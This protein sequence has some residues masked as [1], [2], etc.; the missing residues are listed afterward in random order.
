MSSFQGAILSSSGTLQN[1][2]N[3][4]KIVIQSVQLL[5]EATLDEPLNKISFLFSDHAYVAVKT[6]RNIKVAHKKIQDKSI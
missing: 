6:G 3:V 1:N 2:E 5:S 4:G